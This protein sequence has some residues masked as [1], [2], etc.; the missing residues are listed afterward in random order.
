MTWCI[1]ITHGININTHT[2][3]NA[4]SYSSTRYPTFLHSLNEKFC[5]IPMSKINHAVVAAMQVV[6]RFIYFILNQIW[7]MHQDAISTMY[8]LLFTNRNHHLK[9]MVNLKR[10]ISCSS[11]NTRKIVIHLFITVSLYNYFLLQ[12]KNGTFAFL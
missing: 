2:H 8:V 11:Q 12:T 10:N 4:Q 5:I 3:T 6:A 7:A 1:I 9:M